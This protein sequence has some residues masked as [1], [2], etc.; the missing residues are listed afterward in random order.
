MDFIR[1]CLLFQGDVVEIA[2][3]LLFYVF[4]IYIAFSFVTIRL[5]IG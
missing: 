2:I 1:D 5:Q 4:I 3:G